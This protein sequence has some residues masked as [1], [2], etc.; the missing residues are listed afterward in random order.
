M[1]KRFITVFTVVF[2]VK[3]TFP[4]STLG[5]WMA[6]RRSELNNATHNTV[7]C[8]CGIL[9]WTSILKRAALQLENEAINTYIP[10]GVSEVNRG[11]FLIPLGQV[12][13]FQYVHCT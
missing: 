5:L 13:V 4:L 3:L 1:I 7:R 2:R 10:N 11:P 12:K 9:M 8:P 6:G